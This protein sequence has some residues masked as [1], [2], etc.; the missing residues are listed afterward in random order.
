MVLRKDDACR[1]KEPSGSVFI[2]VISDWVETSRVDMEVAES[3]VIDT[4]ENLQG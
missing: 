3:W 1:W 2:L 4:E